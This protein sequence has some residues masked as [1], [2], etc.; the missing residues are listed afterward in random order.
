MVSTCQ[1]L[2]SLSERE[3][4]VL[5]LMAEGLSNHAISQHLFLSTRTVESHVRSIFIRLNL[6][7]ELGHHRRV[8]AV[9]NYLHATTRSHEEVAV[10]HN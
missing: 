2:D 6:A 4:V 7:P 3:R 1:P 8:L 9:L 10:L 5:E